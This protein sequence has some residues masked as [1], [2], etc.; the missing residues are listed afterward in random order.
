M[1]K[2]GHNEKRKMIVSVWNNGKHYFTGAG[3]GIK[4]KAKDRDVRFDKRWKHIFLIL[5]GKYNEVQIN[6]DKKSFWDSVCKELCHKEIGLWIR[7]N[8]KVPWEKGKPYK[9]IMEYIRHNRFKLMRGARIN[10]R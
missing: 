5:E 6:I 3:Y 10:Q 4:I 9:L 1:Y 8:F 2:E 7:K